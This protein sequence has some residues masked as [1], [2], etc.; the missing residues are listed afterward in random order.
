M[1]ICA[2]LLQIEIAVEPGVERR[3]K[4]ATLCFNHL[5]IPFQHNM[6]FPFDLK[7]SLTFK[8]F[9]YSEVIVFVLRIFFLASNRICPF[10]IG[11]VLFLLDLKH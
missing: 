6:H 11:Q 7:I 8:F 1:E 9:L 2:I 10:T 4:L 3:E 5:I